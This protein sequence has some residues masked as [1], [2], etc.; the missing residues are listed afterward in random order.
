LEKLIDSDSDE[1]DEPG[2]SPGEVTTP[3]NPPR[4]I[5][6]RNAPGLFSF[7]L[8]GLLAVIVVILL[9]LFARWL[10]HVAHNNSQPTQTGTASQSQ[11]S[12]SLKKQ[13]SKQP[14]SSSSAARSSSASSSSNSSTS[15][16]S[17]NSNKNLPNSGAGNVIVI[18]AGA[19]L[20]AAGLHY[21]VSL[22][23]QA[24]KI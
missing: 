18:F 12:S 1:L 9:V 20:A 2:T 4:E 8:F 7:V 17:S 23:R 14:Q 11:S 21:M 13:T 6:Q 19:S 22:R 24:R 10:Y 16:T 3:A 15:S 5:H